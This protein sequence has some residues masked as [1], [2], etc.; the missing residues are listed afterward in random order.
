MV[1]TAEKR[2]LVDKAVGSKGGNAGKA[3]PTQDGRPGEPPI[4]TA[5]TA[6]FVVVTGGVLNH[7]EIPQ[8]PGLD[9][10]SGQMMHT[11]R[12]KH[13]VS[14]GSRGKRSQPGLKRKNVRIVGTGAAAAELRA[15]QTSCTCS[16]ARP[17][18]WTNAARDSH[19]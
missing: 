19:R 17:P 9:T 4:D 2:N 5:V 15:G 13:D 6:Q 16:S 10:S 11:S 18:V 1:T 12:R 8:V 3:Q 14:G 7:P